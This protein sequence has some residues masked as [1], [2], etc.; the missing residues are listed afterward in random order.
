MK[1]LGIDLGTLD[2]PP[3]LPTTAPNCPGG[4]V[5]V[6]RHDFDEYVRG[7]ERFITPRQDIPF[8]AYG[9]ARIWCQN[10]V[11]EIP[12]TSAGAKTYYGLC[13]SCSGAELKNR[14]ELRARAKIREGGR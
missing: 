7:G 14:T 4:L 11:A 8:D 3:A 13:T 1:R 12:K 10:Q 5:R 6:T 2:A 9:S